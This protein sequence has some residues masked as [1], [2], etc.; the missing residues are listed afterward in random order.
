[1]NLQA[2]IDIEQMSDYDVKWVYDKS[3][4]E[5]LKDSYIEFTQEEV[6]TKKESVSD[7]EEGVEKIETEPSSKESQEHNKEDKQEQ[8]SQE[9]AKKKKSSHYTKQ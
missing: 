4:M 5:A 6:T 7:S 8:E 2:L 9:S 3:G 1:F